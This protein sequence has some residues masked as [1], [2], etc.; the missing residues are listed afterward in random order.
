MDPK[1]LLAQSTVTYP[2]FDP[3]SLG[4]PT[5]QLEKLIGQVIGIL[6]LVAVIYFAIQIIFA[7]YS[8]ISANGDSKKLEEAR[9]SI[10]NS[11]LG[12]FI[13]VIA[14]GI[15]SLIATL[16]GIENPLDLNAL[17]TKMGL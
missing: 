8:F 5:N 15:G 1:H 7:G 9:H 14:I 3:P 6:T 13:V 4:N 10:T 16:L 17:F 11:I 12:L 2:P